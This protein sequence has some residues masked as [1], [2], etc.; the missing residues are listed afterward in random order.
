M[1]IILALIVLISQIKIYGN[2]ND[3]SFLLYTTGVSLIYNNK[4][5]ITQ[6]QVQT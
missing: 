1:W 4:Y 6:G 3:L 2:L 5:K